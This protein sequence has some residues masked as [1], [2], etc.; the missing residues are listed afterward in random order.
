[1][2]CD[3]GHGQYGR[4]SSPAPAEISPAVDVDFAAGV[5][6]VAISPTPLVVAVDTFEMDA[7]GMLRG[8]DDAATATFI[9]PVDDADA[10]SSGKCD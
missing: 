1:M 2:T 9:S 4:S 8:E 6:P 5:I 7:E 3:T 10:L